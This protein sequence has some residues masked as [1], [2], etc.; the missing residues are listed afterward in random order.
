ML[1][2]TAVANGSA[3]GTWTFSGGRVELHPFAP[4]PDSVTAALE[5]EARRITR[6]ARPG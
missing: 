3:V 4:L 2:A 6:L 1:R 5:R